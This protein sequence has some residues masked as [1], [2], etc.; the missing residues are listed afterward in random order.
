MLAGTI[1]RES[2]TSGS[3]FSC[4]PQARRN[5]ARRTGRN[6]N[7]ASLVLP[8]RKKT[9]ALHDGR[10][11]DCPHIKN[12]TK[13][14]KDQ[15]AFLFSPRIMSTPT[16]RSN[17]FT[18]IHRRHPSFKHERVENRWNHY[19]LMASTSLR[20]HVVALMGNV[21]DLRAAHSFPEVA[22][23]RRPSMIRLADVWG[24]PLRRG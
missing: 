15:T 13:R 18:N 8:A 4:K 20:T 7:V 24:M 19:V 2:D 10:A 5:P 21:S 9:E 22:C 17:A 23:A 16:H 6:A 12:Q 14:R 11:S 3:L 1:Q